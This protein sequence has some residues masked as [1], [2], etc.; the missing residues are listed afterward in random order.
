MNVI[1][2]LINEITAN[3]QLILA[4]HIHTKKKESKKKERER[5]RE[6][7]FEISNLI[8]LQYNVHKK[9]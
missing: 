6:R 3:I 5:E 4:E 9:N 8:L 1:V 7:H 2:N